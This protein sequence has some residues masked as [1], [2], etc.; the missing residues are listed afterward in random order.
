MWRL[1]EITLLRYLRLFRV[2][3]ERVFR[4]R[5][6]QRNNNKKKKTRQKKNNKL[7]NIFNKGGPCGIFCPACSVYRRNGFSLR[8]VVWAILIKLQI[9]TVSAERH[10]HVGLIRTLGPEFVAWTGSQ[11]FPTFLHPTPQND[12]QKSTPAHVKFVKKKKKQ[13]Y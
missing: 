8:I 5:R 6:K 2:R 1:G 9:E 7:R 11:W 4:C 10:R 3:A 13:T 12:F